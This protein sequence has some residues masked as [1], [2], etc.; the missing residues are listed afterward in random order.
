MH[1]KQ[2]LLIRSPKAL[3]KES[4]VGYGW[5]KVNFSE[6][7]TASALLK[8]G[9]SEKNINIGKKRKQITRYF[10]IKQDDLLVIPT[11]KAIILA[12]ASGNKS[13]LATP[14]QPNTHNRIHVDYIT[15]DGE[16]VYI[17][18]SNLSNAL[19]KRLRVRTAIVD[20][21]DFA[22]ELNEHCQALSNGTLL[23]WND[24]VISLQTDAENHFKKTLLNRLQKGTDTAIISGGEGLEKLIA[25]IL[26]INGYEAVIPAKNQF[27]GITD[28]D[29]LAERHNELTG[30]REQLIIQVKHH[31]GQ[32]S[33]K[34]VR[35][36][37]DYPTN[38][39]DYRFHRKLL[40]TTGSLSEEVQSLAE[41][42]DIATLDGEE[43]IE[44]LYDNISLLDKST[45]S[46]LGV[47]IG[48]S[49]I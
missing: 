23:T 1:D 12:I 33:D 17:P 31:K 21:S 15:T 29:I 16:I 20:L 35:Q 26:N 40:I 6:Y 34:G 44:W 43:F 39:D 24:K 41:Q 4:T 45:L 46:M 8:H 5:S 19:Q 38:N 42:H 13:F 28:A 27:Q 30:D 9:F 2:Y 36:L 25:K 37:I 10:N 7:T 3:I 49:L 48:P 22:D 18:R 47:F 11:T 14:L 32:T